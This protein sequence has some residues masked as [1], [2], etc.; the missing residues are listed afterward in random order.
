MRLR[1]LMPFYEAEGGQGGG[2]AGGTGGGGGT[3]AQGQQAAATQQTQPSAIDYDR[4]AQI[5]EG[6]Q[7]A[8]EESVLKGYFKQQGLTKEQADQ[9][10][11]AFKQQ[12][13]ANQ[14]DVGAMQAQLTQAQAAA[15][16]AQI[17]SAAT[18]AA[19]ALGIDAKTIPYV[20]KM[21]DLSQVMGQDGKIN[22]ETLKAALNK[23]LE[24]VPA[25]KPQAAG[26]TGFTQVG[27]AGGSSQQAQQTTTA[28]QASVATKR[29][30]R[31][32]N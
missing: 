26:V 15:Q 7:A 3:S 27:A 18:M 29:W 13:A 22:E 4:I 11:A 16:Q 17:Q 1:R 10:I 24:D 28:P 32:N 8:T 23:V 30:N 20:L 21:A 19:V 12:Q 31:F 6:K 2:G 9:A 5:L 14:P 25:L